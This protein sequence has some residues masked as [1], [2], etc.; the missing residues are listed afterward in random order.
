MTAIEPFV[1]A[2]ERI[3]TSGEPIPRLARM[4]GG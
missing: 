4:N 3:E 1:I 2:S